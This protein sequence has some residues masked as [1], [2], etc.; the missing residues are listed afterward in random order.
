M[1]A[2]RVSNGIAILLLFAGGYGLASYSGFQPWKTGLTMVADRSHRSS[3]SRSRS[4]DENA[5]GCFPWRPCSDSPPRGPGPRRSRRPGRTRSRWKRPQ[6]GSYSA[7]LY[8]YFIPDDTDYA[9]PTVIANHGGLHLEGR[10]QYEGRRDGLRLGR[11]GTSVVGEKAPSR[12]DAHGRRRLRR[13][14][15]RR[16][17]LRADAA[18]RPL[19]ALQRGRV[20]LRHRRTRE[21]ASSTTGRSSAIRRSSGS[22]LA[23]PRSAPAPTRRASTS[24]AGSFVGFTCRNVKLSVFVFNP[25]WETPTVVTALAV[26]F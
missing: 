16:P 12:C 26:S 15:W 3:Q 23:S 17:R 1:L 10:Y 13:H 2:L 14:A 19:R 6:L 5:S 22:R 9:Q 24:S 20:R 8:G 21:T 25:G 7:S 4:A 11:N 18:V